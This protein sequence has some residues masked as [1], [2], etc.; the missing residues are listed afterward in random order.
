MFDQLMT[1][2]E[3]GSVMLLPVL[4]IA[5]I[6]RHFDEH[7]VMRGMLLGAI[8]SL[9]GIV[10][11]NNA[12]ELIPGI[13]TDPRAAVIALSGLFG[14]PI[15]LVIT[16][17]TLVGMRL[18]Q[19][20][21]GAIPGS[22]YISG[23]AL[24]MGFYWLWTVRREA[25]ALGPKDV[26]AAALIAGVA[27]LVILLF[28]SKVPWPVFIASNALAIPTNVL[29]VILVGALLVRER[30]RALAI[31]RQTEKQ[32]QINAI[33]VN[34]PTVIFQVR[35]CRNG[36]PT[37]TYIS[38]ASERI[39]GHAPGQFTGAQ[40]PLAT[41]LSPDDA[42]TLAAQF[43]TH[44]PEGES[45]SLELPYHHPLGASWLRIDAGARR[46]EN[47]MQIWD[48]TITDIAAQRAAEEMKD[49][50]I[51]VVSHELRTPLTSIRGA[52]GLVLA[53]TAGPALPPA[54]E[55]MLRIANRNAERLVH[56]VNEILDSQKIRAGEMTF[57]IEDQPLRPIITAAIHAIDHYAPEKDLHITFDNRAGDGQAA[58]DAHRL[59]LVL[60]NLLSNATKF[61]PQGS[62]ITVTSRIVGDAIRLSVTDRGPGV[63]EDFR[64]HVFDRFRQAQ[65]AHDRAAGGT[66]LGLNIA[67]TF[68]IAMG[69]RIWF[70]TETNVGTTFH[71]EFLESH[72][73]QQVKDAD[74]IA[75]TTA[76]I[77]EDGRLPLLLYVE[78]DASLQ[79]IM[80]QRIGQHARVVSAT[81]LAQAAT[82]QAQDPADI[83]LLDIDLPDGQGTQFLDILPVDTPVILFTALEVPPAI[84]ERATRVMVK[85]RI[86]EGDVIDEV[87][88]LIGA[89]SGPAQRPAA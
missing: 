11:M 72:G 31:T 2:I 8:F 6:R 59:A 46:G 26:L 50:F 62:E 71:V 28:V 38:P 75:S 34:A 82:F 49:N 36:I 73:S 86:P 12:V 7:S 45:W 88:H 63:P 89:Q 81:T 29:A 16:T 40:T 25:E 41:L 80:R 44:G 51:S 32:A 14:G 5:E 78:D 83:V 85:S 57:D 61:A 37:L 47:G 53:P 9:I 18:E 66:G 20:G 76:S 4:L 3:S 24:I 67:K 43:D 69:G 21:L 23:T 68:V 87:L 56:L 17:A 15:S 54:K 33:A 52:L 84:A 48:G 42:Q 79:Q 64:D 60:Q 55:K 22:V 39:L 58:V 13:R 74:V 35:R 30:E 65:A 19:G 27:P 77:V 1:M 10:V 70:E